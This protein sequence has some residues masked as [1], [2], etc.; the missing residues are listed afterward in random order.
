M[1]GEGVVRAGGVVDGGVFV[2][3]RVGGP[4]VVGE[5]FRVVVSERWVR[6]GGH[7]IRKGVVAGIEGISEQGE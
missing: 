3:W 6:R 7:V 4:G 1:G 2:G 5:A